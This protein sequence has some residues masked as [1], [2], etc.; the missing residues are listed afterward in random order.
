METPSVRVLVVGDSGVGKTTLLQALCRSPGDSSSSRASSSGGGGGATWTTGCDAHVLVRSPS[1]LSQCPSLT[2]CISPLT[3]L[4]RLRIGLQLHQYRENG[5]GA[6]REVF[7]EFV[8]VGGHQKYA[9]SR[10]AFYHDVHG[11]IFVH[12]LS[13]ARSCEHLR[14]W[15][16]EIAATQRVK[17]CVVPDTH[18]QMR[19]A[20]DFPTLKALPKLILGT[21]K[22]LLPRGAGGKRPLLQTPEFQAVSCMETVRIGLNGGVKR[23]EVRSDRLWFRMALQS[24]EPLRMEPSGAFAAFLQQT[25]VFAN[26][27][28][29]STDDSSSFSTGSG[30]RQTRSKPAE[31][32]AGS[33]LSNLASALPPLS[34]GSG[35]ARSR[36]W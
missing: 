5:F 12:D 24:A 36:W 11:V 34:T 33:R 13:N 15:S 22:D 31:P 25:I 20:G 19:Q 6:E 30:L 26:R 3:A 35:G 29:D 18:H 27:G 9:L 8:D 7:V 1:F 32:E 16:L 17:G 14:S 21:K 23:R 4:L 10:A 2:T 28:V